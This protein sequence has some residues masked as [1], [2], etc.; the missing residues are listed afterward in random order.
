MLPSL[1]NTV[2]TNTEDQIKLH[3]FPSRCVSFA[4]N[5]NMVVIFG[6]LRTVSLFLKLLEDS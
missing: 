3:R 2:R 5:K 1:A 4:K 6:P